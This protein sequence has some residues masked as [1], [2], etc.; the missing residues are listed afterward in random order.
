LRHDEI[1]QLTIAHI[2]CDAFYASI[3]K[4]DNP[5]LIDQ[6]VIVGGGVRGVVSTACYIARMYGVRSAMP[7]FKAKKACPDAVVVKPRMN[8]YAKEGKRIRSMMETLTPLVEPL[9]ID[10]A[11]LDLSGT[12]RL[13]DAPPSLSLLCLQRQIKEEVGVSVSVGLSFNKFLAKTASDLDKPNGFSLIGRAEAPDFLAKLPVSAVFGIGPVMAKKLNG[14]GL[15]TLSDVLKLDDSVLAKRYGEQGLRLA[16]LARAEDAR[17]VKTDS[18]R[19][20]VSKET[21]FNTDISDKEQLKAKLLRLSE[22]VA[23]QMK[24]NQI[25]GR[26]VTLKLK[27]DQF[28][29][30]TRRR[31]LNEPT[32]L[33]D[34]LFRVCGELLDREP[35]GVRYR[36][37]GAGFSD[38]S[39]TVEAVASDLLDPD[40]EKRAKAER[41]VD[42]ARA[43]FGDGAIIKGRLLKS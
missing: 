6:P 42:A 27:T 30:T 33:A 20:S 32:Q 16:K 21:T 34:T 39:N 2:D 23:A 10:E 11:F 22:Q 4:R 41:A 5:D 13:H 29:T 25:S 43:K 9:S 18:A 1:N 19:K 35:E 3:E 38:L 12:E 8:V 28:K 37:I 40:A 31:T 7:M 26:V 15:R 17:A 24:S 14:D 36:L